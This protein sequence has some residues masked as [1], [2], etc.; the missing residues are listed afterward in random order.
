MASILNVDQIRTAAGTNAMTI[1]SSGYVSMPNTTELDIWNLPANVTISSSTTQD[2]TTLTRWAVDWE[3]IGTGMSHS[4][5]VFTFPSTGKWRCTAKLYWQS[6]NTGVYFGIVNRFSTDSGANYS[7][8]AYA[9]QNADNT[10]YCDTTTV[11]YVDV[12]NASTARAKFSIQTHAS[13]T[14]GGNTAQLRTYVVFEKLAA[15]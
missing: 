12:T 10:E 8:R 5:G 7:D 14:M 11:M 4:S 3:K 13:G 15:T 1:D 2:I 6:S 9:Y